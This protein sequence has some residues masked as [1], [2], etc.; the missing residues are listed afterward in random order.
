MSPF[1]PSIT[2]PAG[3][4]PLHNVIGTAEI[5]SI[6]TSTLDDIDNLI[7]LLVSNPFI[8]PAARDNT[9]QALTPLHRAAITKNVR[10]VKKLLKSSSKSNPSPSSNGTGRPITRSIINVADAQGKTPLW[11]ACSDPSRDP[12]LIKVLAQ[13]GGHFGAVTC[14]RI[15]GR[16]ASGIKKLLENE[17]KKRSSS[18]G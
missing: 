7:S 8:D 3:L 12:D 5:S 10:A 16:S 1:S 9:A 17:F 4:G 6:S 11:H 14:P 2:D 13:S 18:R 15:E